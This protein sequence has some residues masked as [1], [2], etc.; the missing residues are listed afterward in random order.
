[1]RYGLTGKSEMTQKEVADYFEISQS[2]ISRIEKKILDKMKSDILKL[3]WELSRNV[4]FDFFKSIF[5][6]SWNLSLTNS[7]GIRNFNLCFSGI[8]SQ[9]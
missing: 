2:Y 4:L 1:M 6:K 3:A 7:N 5:F 9:K 8:I